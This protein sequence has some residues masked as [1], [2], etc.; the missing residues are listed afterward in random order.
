MNIDE[1][2]IHAFYQYNST[3]KEVGSAITPRSKGFL[4]G[5]WRG[6]SMTD[7]A[8]LAGFSILTQDSIAYG[9]SEANESD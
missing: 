5:K 8:R 6:N 9:R 7:S 3:I 1:I 4:A 2:D